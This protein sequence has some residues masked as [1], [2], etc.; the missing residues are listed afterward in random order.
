MEVSVDNLIQW[1]NHSGLFQKDGE[2]KGGVH[3]YFDQNSS[4]FG[5]LLSFFPENILNAERFSGTILGF[6]LSVFFLEEFEMFEDTELHPLL[7]AHLFLLGCQAT[8]PVDLFVGEIEV[9]HYESFEL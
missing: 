5:F 7:L 4:K 2:N 6:V 3:S 9:G 8:E 1:I